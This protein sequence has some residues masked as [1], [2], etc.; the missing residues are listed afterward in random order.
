MSDD[1]VVGWARPDVEVVRGR[2]GGG[3]VMRVTAAAMKEMENADAVEGM[4]NADDNHIPSP[5]SC[6]GFWAERPDPFP[7]ILYPSPDRPRIAEAGVRADTLHRGREEEKIGERVVRVGPDL[8]AV[9]Q[10]E[11]ADRW[12]RRPF[13]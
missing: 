11:G 4:V 10:V 7:H 3:E 5:D 6:F 2:P 13:V 12:S 8:P 1:D 9:R